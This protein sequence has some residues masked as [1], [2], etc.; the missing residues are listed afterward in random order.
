MKKHVRSIK[1]SNTSIF[2]IETYRGEAVYSIRG[3][4]QTAVNS[5]QKRRIYHKDY[6]QHEQSE[7]L[8]Y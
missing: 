1:R 7:A 3:R 5:C 6:D 8:Q 2:I 4:S